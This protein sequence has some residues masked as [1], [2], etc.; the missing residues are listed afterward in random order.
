MDISE[1]YVYAALSEPNLVGADV[2]LPSIPLAGQGD[3]AF[4]HQTFDFSPNAFA[5]LYD[6]NQTLYTVKDDG[7][8]IVPVDQ[9]ALRTNAIQYD[10]S[11]IQKDWKELLRHFTFD[12][13]KDLQ[14][15]QQGQA[16][17]AEIK[18]HIH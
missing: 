14:K 6:P 17:L 5:L 11:A 9:S 18:S 3:T 7:M 4:A 2:A 8:T 1:N 16:D 13:P 12:L 10:A 15:T